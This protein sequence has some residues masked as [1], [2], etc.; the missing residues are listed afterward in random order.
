MSHKII[1]LEDGRKLRLT[2]KQEECSNFIGKNPRSTLTDVYQA[3]NNGYT[4]RIGIKYILEIL[5]EYK[6]VIKKGLR[7][8]LS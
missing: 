3:V 4:S 8:E 5:V 1:D 6:L 2:S 7:Y